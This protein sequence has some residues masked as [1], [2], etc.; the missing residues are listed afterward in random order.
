MDRLALPLDLWTEYL[1]RWLSF[2]HWLYSKHDIPASFELH[3]QAWLA[4]EPAKQT[5]TEQLVLAIQPPGGLPDILTR[6]KDPRRARL[7]QLD[8][9]AA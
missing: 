2:R 5:P 1:G 9:D 8:K 4:V 3:A 6:G 7:R